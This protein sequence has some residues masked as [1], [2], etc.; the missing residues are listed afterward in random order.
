M[1]GGGGKCLASVPLH[2]CFQLPPVCRWRREETGK[3]LA[4]VPVQIKLTLFSCWV[5]FFE[6]LML[7]VGRLLLDVIASLFN[8]N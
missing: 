7:L 4:Y 5:S 3:M 6:H 8:T 2:C 1:A